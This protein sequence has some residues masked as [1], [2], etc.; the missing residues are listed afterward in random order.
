LIGCVE[1]SV[2]GKWGGRYGACFFNLAKALELAL[3]D[4]RD[5]RTGIQLL[6]GQGDLST[7]TSFGEIMA[8]YKA[9]IEFYAHQQAIKD[10]VQDLAWEA[11]IP[12]PLISSLTSD[13]LGR[14]KELKKGGAIYDYTGGQ[15]GSI[16]NIANSLAAI[17][18]LV[19]EDKVLTGA[20]LKQA[21]DTNFE[22]VEGEKI[23]QMLLTKAPKYG[24]DDPY[25]DELAREA[26]SI[27]FVQGQKY[28][29]TRWG[30]G[31]IGCRWHPST[32]AVASN[33]PGGATVGALPDGRKAGIP[34]ADTESPTHG[35]DVKGPTAVVKSASKLEHRL[36]SGGSI[37]NMRIHPSNF[38]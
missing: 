9:Q 13:C 30:R 29:N 22:G 32:A 36:L 25:V 4:G 16:A 34:L 20:Q 37:L 2:Q 38:D 14:G 6:Q 12:T 3:N 1:P 15:T 23:R 7:F 27:Y 8:A 26:S 31:P 5:P 24:N 10:N 11:L 28:K 17:K 18:K 21:I 19:F 33:V 35:T